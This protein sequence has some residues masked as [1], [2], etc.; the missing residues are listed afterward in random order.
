MLL[1]NLGI[2]DNVFLNILKAHLKNMSEMFVDEQVAAQ[3][4]MSIAS[5]DCS[6]LQQAGVHIT[7]EPYLRS[8]LM[9]AYRYRTRRH[10]YKD[11]V[12]VLVDVYTMCLMHMWHIHSYNWEFSSIKVEHG[13]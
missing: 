1:S 7:S 8:L 3:K 2:T 4:M 11:L 5:V 10:C 13:L 9:A 6:G 12:S